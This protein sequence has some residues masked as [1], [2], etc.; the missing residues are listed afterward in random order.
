MKIIKT[1]ELISLGAT[2]YASYL[3]GEQGTYHRGYIYALVGIIFSLFMYRVVFDRVKSAK[4]TFALLF[5]SL[6]FVASWVVV[7]PSTYAWYLNI[8]SSVNME[9]VIAD[10]N[11]KELK[12]TRLEEIINSRDKKYLSL[13][14]NKNLWI[15]SK[16]EEL[17]KLREEWKEL[18]DN[19]KWREMRDTKYAS[20][21]AKYRDEKLGSGETAIDNLANL[22]YLDYIQ[23][24]SPSGKN[25]VDKN[26]IKRLKREIGIDREKI[27]VDIPLE[28]FYMVMG[29][30]GILIEFLITH[31]DYW[32][33][34]KKE[35][36]RLIKFSDTMDIEIL[37]NE[38]VFLDMLGVDRPNR[39][40]A[41]IYA[42]F[43]SLNKYGIVTKE[44]MKKCMV[45]RKANGQKYVISNYFYSLR[46]Q[47][48]RE[49]IDLE[50]GI[51]YNLGKIKERVGNA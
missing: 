9:K 17:R 22:L 24:L 1:Q 13:Q 41:L 6:P 44:T 32:F 11:K 14:D 10:I 5:F 50:K 15:E 38:L 16:K 40:I 42:M 7:A 20:I 25:L 28:Y 46:K 12:I 34:P 43:L 18:K 3:L 36:H 19:K 8:T 45:F 39:E 27:K 48:E 51:S 33:Q 49:G 26:E 21:V 23:S 35:Y 37:E 30:I 29:I 2:A 31:V 4:A 47:L